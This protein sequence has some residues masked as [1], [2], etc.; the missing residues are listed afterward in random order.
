MLWNNLKSFERRVLILLLSNFSL[1]FF[2]LA[3]LLVQQT[4]YLRSWY[5]SLIETAIVGWKRR[6]SSIGHQR[7]NLFVYV[8][9]IEGDNGSGDTIWFSHV[10]SIHLVQIHNMGISILVQ[11]VLY[12]LNLLVLN[13]DLK[14]IVP[15]LVHVVNFGTS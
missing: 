7:N 3:Y 2:A 12:L 10:T 9:I 6:V 5:L 14:S 13:A 15:M 11:K 8:A 4:P 1:A